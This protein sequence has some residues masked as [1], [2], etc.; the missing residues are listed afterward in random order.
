MKRAAPCPGAWEMQWLCTRQ[1]THELAHKCQLEP[2]RARHTCVTSSLV[3]PRLA[4]SHYTT[5]TLVGPAVALTVVLPVASSDSNNRCAHL[6]HISFLKDSNS[7]NWSYR[8]TKQDITQHQ[9]IIIGRNKQLADIEGWLERGRERKWSSSM[10]E[11]E[12]RQRSSIG[13]R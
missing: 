11:G 10:M 6:C 8:H 2:S 5:L 3:S 12:G 13:S 9:G 7:D 4:Q 1:R